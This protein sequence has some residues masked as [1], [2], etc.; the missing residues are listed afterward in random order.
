M[1][2][3]CKSGKTYD[4][5]TL[6]IVFLSTLYA[7]VKFG[8]A[9]TFFESFTVARGAASSVYQ[10][11][12]RI[13]SIDSSSTAGLRL[14]KLQGNI[15]FENVHF[16]YPPRPEMIVLNGMSLSVNFGQTVALMGSSR[17]GKST[18]VQLL[19]RFYDPCHGR[20]T[21]EEIDIKELNVRWLRDQIG[22]AGH[23]P[24]LFA[25][26]IGENIGY[27]LKNATH[28]P[29]L[30]Q[31]WENRQ[32]LLS[33][34][35][36]LQMFLRDAKQAEVLLA[37]Q[38]HLLSKEEMPSNLEQAENAIKRHEAFMT[39]MDTKLLA[40]ERAQQYTAEVYFFDVS[41]AEAW[42]SEQGLYMMVKDRGKDEISAQNFMKK[43]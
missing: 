24:V 17:C 14:D 29:E 30:H 22:V 31:M 13:P 27:G 19:Q 41:E 43:H 10:I 20:I 42:M 36:N 37:Q 32:Q 1:V 2:D 7:A 26:S 34:S 4:A 11:I 6:K 38:K 5:A 18:C 8:Q 23:E 15:Q 25:T 39:T 9:L 35:L 33:Q 3:S 16:H 40:S 28:D 21:I 12:E